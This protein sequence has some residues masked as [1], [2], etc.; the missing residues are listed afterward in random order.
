MPEMILYKYKYDEILFKALKEDTKEETY[1]ILDIL[2]YKYNYSQNDMFISCID[3]LITKFK[4]DLL[5]IPYIIKNYSDIFKDY[6][7]ADEAINI[8]SLY[9]AKYIQFK[10]KQKK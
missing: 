7:N 5:D 4:K 1:F 3:S 10:L 2:K 6:F 8:L 9:D